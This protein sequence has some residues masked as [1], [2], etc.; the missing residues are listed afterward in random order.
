MAGSSAA[1]RSWS[2]PVR[3]G[4]P[5]SVTSEPLPQVIS[6]PW[7]PST[8]EPAVSGAEGTEARSRSPEG[9]PAPAVL[10]RGHTLPLGSR[11]ATQPCLSLPSRHT[12]QGGGP[13]WGH[14]HVLLASDQSLPVE[15]DGRPARIPQPSRPSLWPEDTL[16]CRSAWLIGG[17]EASKK[18]LRATEGQMP[19]VVLTVCLH[20]V[21]LGPG[22]TPYPRL[23]GPFSTD[24][25]SRDWGIRRIRVPV[26]T[27]HGLLGRHGRSLSR[28]FLKG[29]VGVI[30][31]GPAH[32]RL[33]HR[34][35][36]KARE[37]PRPQ[38][39]PPSRSVR[40][41]DVVLRDT[42]DV[43][44]TWRGTLSP[45]PLRGSGRRL[46]RWPHG[47][48]SLN[49]KPLV[50]APPRP[51]LASVTSLLQAHGGSWLGFSCS[52]LGQLVS[53]EGSH[54][55]VPRCPRPLSPQAGP[56]GRLHPGWLGLVQRDNR[57][58]PAASMAVGTGQR[59]TPGSGGQ[60]F[61]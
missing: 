12:D 5:G 54:L 46:A 20:H 11:A 27:C 1:P 22:P 51:G 31:Q 10:S 9:A 7:F 23:P 29:K 52:P 3:A 17:G 49:T 48:A 59:A 41:T 4:R 15:K 40:T 33:G 58:G 56:R 53:D 55:T 8:D 16:L 43:A 61:R 14:I 6:G 39:P 21:P 28:S 24:L 34:S 32:G 45:G 42:G 13:C 38:T 44:G 25:E 19:S 30:V 26:V 50:P 35:A 18:P 60:D 37:P 57:W 2:E 47:T 36:L